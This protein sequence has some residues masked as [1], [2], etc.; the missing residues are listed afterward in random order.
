MTDNP[1]CPDFKPS[2]TA[3]WLCAKWTH[4]STALRCT[5][6]CIDGLDCETQG[7]RLMSEDQPIRKVKKGG[8]I[9]ENS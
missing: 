3:P 7:L 4:P 6:F 9:N 8:N 5:F 1:H 2:P